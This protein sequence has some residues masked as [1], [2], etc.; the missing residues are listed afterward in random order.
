MTERSKAT[1]CSIA[2]GALLTL[3]LFI[4]SMILSGQNKLEAEDN[5]LEC[6]VRETEKC[7]EVLKTQNADI[8]K[9]LDRIIELYEK[10]P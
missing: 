4:L 6:R 2:T 5:D 8:I 7:I 9:R 10:N 3:I 1:A